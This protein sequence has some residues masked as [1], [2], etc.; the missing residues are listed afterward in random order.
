[1]QPGADG[2]KGSGLFDRGAVPAAAAPAR[3]SRPGLASLVIATVVLA[4]AG[5]WFLSSRSDPDVPAMAMVTTEQ[6]PGAITTLNPGAQQTARSDARECRFPM[7]FITVAT[8]GNPAGG[9]VR[10]R[11]SKYQSPPFH[12]TDKP[13]QIAIPSPLP[14]TGGIDLLSADGDAKGL[15]VSLYPAARM[16]P[17]NGSSTIRVVWPAQPPCK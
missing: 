8:P 12:I 3:V 6:I 7:G 17:V 2:D 15:L 11:T 16:E 13:Q 1:M 14:G 5:G 9:T 4:A 10:F